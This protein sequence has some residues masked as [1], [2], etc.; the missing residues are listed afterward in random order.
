MGRPEIYNRK[1]R[2]KTIREFP[3]Y[4]NFQI[5]KLKTAWNKEVRLDYTWELYILTIFYWSIF[6][7]LFYLIYEVIKGIVEGL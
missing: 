5:K 4:L 3:T 1:L 6:T 7:F 2:L